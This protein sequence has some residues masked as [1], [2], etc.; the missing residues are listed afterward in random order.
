MFNFEVNYTG[1]DKVQRSLNGLFQSFSREFQVGV[2]TRVGQVY[3]AD[4]KSRFDREY[5]VDRKKWKPLSAATIRMKKRGDKKRGPAVRG[6]THRGIWTEALQKSLD[7]RI[8]G[9]AVVIGSDVEYAPYFH[10]GVKMGQLKKI[11]QYSTAPWGVIPPRRFLGRNN[12]IDKKVIGV[13]QEELAKKIGIT[14]QQAGRD[15]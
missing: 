15:L 3:I 4:T 5:D 1:N 11:G 9:N 2:L 14:V 7:M 13:I 10:Y 8:D 6:A 12:R